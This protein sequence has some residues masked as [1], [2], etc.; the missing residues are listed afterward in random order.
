M[1]S[2]QYV[3]FA[4]PSEG[5]CNPLLVMGQDHEYTGLVSGGG[6]RAGS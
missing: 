5:A 2:L 6:L 1:Y 3:R 4:F